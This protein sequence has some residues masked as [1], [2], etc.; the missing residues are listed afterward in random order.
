M[1]LYYMELLNYPWLTM[2]MYFY[3]M[4]HISYNFY[5]KSVL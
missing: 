1:G 2:Y 4:Q 3:V 5:I